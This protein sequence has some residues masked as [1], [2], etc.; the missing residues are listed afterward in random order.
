LSLVVRPVRLAQLVL[1]QLAV[2][3]VEPLVRAIQQVSLLA[4]L[5]ERVQ[6]VELALRVMDQAFESP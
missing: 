1:P 2:A 5:Q 3:P 6:L 4:K